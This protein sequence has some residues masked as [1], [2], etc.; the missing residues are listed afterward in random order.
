[1]REI[2]IQLKGETA[3]IIV[4]PVGVGSFAQSVVS[5]C[6]RQ[7]GLTT[8]MTVEPEAAAC[9]WESLQKSESV[10]IDTSHTIMSGLNCGTVSTIAWPILKAGV[11]ASLTVAE[12]EAHQAV[13]D[14]EKCGVKAGPCGASGLAALRRL[15][16]QDR[17]ALGVGPDSVCV[18]LCTERS[19][20]YDPPA[21]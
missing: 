14:L 19:R 6:R 2:D 12:N 3:D 16:P 20:P 13:I 17:A 1:M 18:L 5:H 10:S 9:L 21:S 15:S 11:G 8:V 7:A 4:A